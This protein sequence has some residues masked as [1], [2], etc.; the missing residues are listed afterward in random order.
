KTSITRQSNGS[1]PI[2]QTETIE[3]SANGTIIDTTKT[4][5]TS[6]GAL[7]LMTVATTSAN[8]LVRTFG[9]AVNGHTSVDFST[10][11]TI[12]LNADGSRTETVANT[13]SA[14][15]ISETVTTT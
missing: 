5:T 4:Y 12:V 8:G 1:V 14:G 15:L 6:G 7:Q 3:P 11:D 9:T 2:Y 13:N 10:T